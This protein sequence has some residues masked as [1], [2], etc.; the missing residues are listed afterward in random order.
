MTPKKKAKKKRLVRG[1][2]WHAWAWR[3]G[4]GS[5]VRE[6]YILHWAEPSKPAGNSYPS[7][8]GKPTVTGKWVRVKFVEV[9][10]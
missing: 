3:V 6:G 8:T 2:D 7:E 10:S 5:V 4:K 1:K 9:K